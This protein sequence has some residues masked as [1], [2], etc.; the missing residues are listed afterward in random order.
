M[1]TK[2]GQTSYTNRQGNSVSIFRGL[3]GQVISIKVEGTGSNRAF[4]AQIR[5]ARTRANAG[6]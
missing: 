3:E 4:Q 5:A 6:E 2:A 1:T